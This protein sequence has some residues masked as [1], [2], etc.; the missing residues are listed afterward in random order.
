MGRDP[1]RVTKRFHNDYEGDLA[2]EV[3][4]FTWEKLDYVDRLRQEFDIVNS[5]SF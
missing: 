4:L 5:S 3:E 2:I 1:R